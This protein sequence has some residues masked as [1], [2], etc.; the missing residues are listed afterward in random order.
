MLFQEFV[1]TFEISVK[2]IFPEPGKLKNIQKLLSTLK[3]YAKPRG[4]IISAKEVQRK[5]D[6]NEINIVNCS[7]KINILF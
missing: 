2:M 1:T 4:I 7:K 5:F 3:T 6:I